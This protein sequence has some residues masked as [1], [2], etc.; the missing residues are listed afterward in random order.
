MLGK[1]QNTNYLRKDEFLLKNKRKNKI[2]KIKSRF[3]II[4]K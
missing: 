4:S 2:L 3:I 1:H